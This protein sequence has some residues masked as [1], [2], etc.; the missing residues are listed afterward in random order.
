MKGILVVNAFLTGDRYSALY[1]LLKES[2]TKKNVELDIITNKDLL[3]KINDFN[4]KCDFVIY[5]DKDI[6]LSRYLEQRGYKVFN[7]SKAIELCD[8]KGLTLMALENKGIKIPKTI[9]SPFTF[10]NIPY[11]DFSF[12]D[13]VISEI[14][15]PLVVKENKSSFGMGV[16]LVKTKEELISLLKDK[17]ER[18]IFQEYIS[19]SK[20]R[21]VRIEVVNGKAIG[22][23]MRTN[24]NDFRSNVLRGGKMSAWKAPNAFI[25]VSE[26]A[27]Q[28][29]G[30][31]FCGVDIMFGNNN[32]PILCEVNSNCHFKTFYTVTNINLADYISDLI[33]NKIEGKKI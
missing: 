28:I 5:W 23:V 14:G 27:A 32:E 3:I 7:N 13:E 19:S 6:L 25:E 26:K 1:D 11:N 8:D 21:D 31:D 30:L 22:S 9:I 16:S 20:G 33:I 17:K 15:L 18:V 4:L 2:F 29:L 10:D 12:V 24:D